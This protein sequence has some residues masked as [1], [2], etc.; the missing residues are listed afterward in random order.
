MLYLVW[1][2][3]RQSSEK[4]WIYQELL[5]DQLH[6]SYH[7]TDFSPVRTVASHEHGSSC[8]KFSV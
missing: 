6:V 1:Q 3:L 2:A 8:K 4:G 7:T 5:F